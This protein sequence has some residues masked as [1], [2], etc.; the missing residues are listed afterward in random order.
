MFLIAAVFLKSWRRRMIHSMY[1]KMHLLGKY[2][3]LIA[4]LKKF[5]NCKIKNV[6]N[7]DCFSLG[8]AS[9]NDFH[10]MFMKMHLLLGKY[11]Q[12]KI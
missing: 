9:E 1:T 6:S 4:K 10:S 3:Y 7:C 11:M 8:V 2:M 5:K 12:L